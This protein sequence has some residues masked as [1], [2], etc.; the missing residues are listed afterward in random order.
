LKRK[1][2]QNQKRRRKIN[3]EEKKKKQNK[4]HTHTHTHKFLSS[5][6]SRPQNIRNNDRESKKLKE[7][8]KQVS[9]R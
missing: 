1:K 7:D 5:K 2:K 8:E 9:S 3:L 6:V 4:T